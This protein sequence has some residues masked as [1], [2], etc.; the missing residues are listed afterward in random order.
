MTRHV[1]YT[2][3]LAN[4]LHPIIFL[5][6]ALYESGSGD[7]R[8]SFDLIDPYFFFALASCA[9]SLPGLLVARV[10]FS[11]IIDNTKDEWMILIYWFATVG[12]LAIVTFIFFSLLLS[13]QIEMLELSIPGVVSACLSVCIR[14]DQLKQLIQK[15]KGPHEQDIA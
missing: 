12:A 1:F 2:W 14:Y 3:L 11:F 5:A 9:I 10:M 13:R 15:Q 7:M 8:V 6:Q 4:P